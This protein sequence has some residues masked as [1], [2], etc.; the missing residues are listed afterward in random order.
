MV[1][2]WL[3]GRH[4]AVEAPIDWGAI[5]LARAARLPAD[6]VDAATSLAR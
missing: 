5:E 1:Q 6:A 3:K 2:A 4:V